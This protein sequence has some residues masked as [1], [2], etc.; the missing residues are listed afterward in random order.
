MSFALE[1]QSKNKE[2]RNKTSATPAKRSSQG[3]G[4]SRMT[5]TSH[6][7]L[8]HL[9]K[10]IG[11]QA[12]QR[13]LRSKVRDVAM[14][15]DI[16]TKLKISQPG[17]VYE[18]EADRI[19]EQ[20]MRMSAHSHI[21]LTESNEEERVDR[22]CSACEMKKMDEEEEK[23]H[24]SRKPSTS[25]NFEASSDVTNKI[26][27]VRSSGSSSLD[28]N[29]QEFMESRFEYDFS[30][31]RL[32]TDELA[33][34]SANAVNAVAYTVGNDIIFSK[35][36]YRPNTLEGRKLLAHELVHV[37][38]KVASN[39][40]GEIAI[41]MHLRQQGSWSLANQRSLAERPNGTPGGRSNS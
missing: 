18:Q 5:M 25:S 4:V 31:V 6:N 28:N 11:N 34:K 40:V 9:Q 30:D 32:H 17:D 27:N 23:L 36:Q 29:T 38:S 16:Q 41:F 26:S 8:I 21:G 14:K 33:S 24:I 19:A 20:V 1:S 37:V 39:T 3:G 10:T 13:L 35:G 12:V 2:A 15:T 22:K 7:S